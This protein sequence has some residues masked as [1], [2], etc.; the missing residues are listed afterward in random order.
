MSIDGFNDSSSRHGSSSGGLSPLASGAGKSVHNSVEAGSLLASKA[1]EHLIDETSSVADINKALA[2]NTALITL[3]Q[4]QIHNIQE[5]LNGLTT[6][7]MAV[8]SN[9]ES[10]SFD[11]SN[12]ITECKQQLDEAQKKLNQLQD[13]RNDLLKKFL[14]ARNKM[15]QAKKKVEEDKKSK[16]NKKPSDNLGNKGNSTNRSTDVSNVV[17]SNEQQTKIEKVAVDPKQEESIAKGKSALQ[18][19]KLLKDKA[20]TKEIEKSGKKL[21]PSHQKSLDAKANS[22]ARFSQKTANKSGSSKVLN[23]KT[24]PGA[25][26]AANNPLAKDLMAKKMATTK[27]VSKGATSLISKAAS[28]IGKGV[29]AI[30]STIGKVLGP[31]MPY[32]LLFVGIIAAFVLLLIIIAAILYIAKPMDRSYTLKTA[33]YL[34]EQHY[35]NDILG[36]LNTRF[37]NED[38]PIDESEISYYN[39]Q[40]NWKEILAYWYCL[41]CSRDG[42]TAENGDVYFTYAVDANN[43]D[44]NIYD[45]VCNL[46]LSTSEINMITESYNALNN[47]IIY[48]DD[49]SKRTSKHFED[50]NELNAFIADLEARGIEYNIYGGATVVYM[51]IHKNAIVNVEQTALRDF[52]ENIND[53]TMKAHIDA[54]LRAVDENNRSLEP[55]FYD[56]WEAIC[57]LTSL[58]TSG[59]ELLTR[60]AYAIWLMSG[61]QADSDCP[62]EARNAFGVEEPLDVTLYRESSVGDIPYPFRFVYWNTEGNDM[63]TVISALPWLAETGTWQR[64]SDIPVF[65]NPEYTFGGSSLVVYCNNGVGRLGFAV[66]DINDD[67]NNINGDAVYFNNVDFFRDKDPDGSLL[68]CSGMNWPSYCYHVIAPNM[69]EPGYYG[70]GSGL[71]WCA[72]FVNSLA[73]NFYPRGCFFTERQLFIDSMNPSWTVY[74]GDENETPWAEATE[75]MTE[76]ITDFNASSFSSLCQS[77]MRLSMATS[78]KAAATWVDDY[79]NGLQITAETNYYRINLTNLHSDLSA[80]LFDGA[81]NGSVFPPSAADNAAYRPDPEDFTDWLG[82]DLG[83]VVR[84]ETRMQGSDTAVQGHHQ[85]WYSPRMTINTTLGAYSNS[86]RAQLFCDIASSAGTLMTLAQSGIVIDVTG[87]AIV[88]LLQGLGLA[89]E[90][91]YRAVLPQ[92]IEEFQT[93]YFS[94]FGELP[95]ETQSLFYNLSYCPYMYDQYSQDAARG[96]PIMMF[97]ACGCGTSMDMY[98]AC[99]GDVVLFDHDVYNQAVLDEIGRVVG[100]ERRSDGVSDHVGLIVWASEDGSTFATIEGNTYSVSG[101]GGYSISMRYYNIYDENIMSIVHLPYGSTSDDITSE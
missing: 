87:D 62:A 66:E 37:Y 95:E 49:Y 71:P 31:I 19:D 10:S 11:P 81:E 15:Q 34:T 17:S 16:D 97:S 79:I 63:N 82:V 41:G 35:H 69:Y 6:A 84:F 65:L 50:S 4:K 92:Y 22:R 40:L 58:D 38:D 52:A 78:G 72:A 29:K 27:G 28:A 47:I 98:S 57:D 85:G 18:K 44:I 68:S 100:Y 94:I 93:R 14:K 67:L 21:N 2:D 7:A 25:K 5:T 73:N 55:T 9:E 48:P 83:S 99:I 26:S 32:I 51:Q 30:A 88:G 60:E 77:I 80:G 3:T 91:A 20:R 39:N 59:C 56:I 12:E 61:A 74:F 46:E 64:W 89:D 75:E 90:N 70:T 96:V 36:E 1:K 45:M 101:E 13:T 43:P 86:R 42:E 23:V 76:A 8:G 53:E 33:V 24:V 54:C